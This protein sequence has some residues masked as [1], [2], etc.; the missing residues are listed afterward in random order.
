MWYHFG[1]RYFD[2]IFVGSVTGSTGYFQ[3]LAYNTASISTLTI[4]S[5]GTFSGGITGSTG[6]F[7]GLIYAKGGI[8]SSTG[9]FD[10]VM[11]SETGNS[12]FYSQ[13]GTFAGGITA[14]TGIFSSLIMVHFQEQLDIL[15]D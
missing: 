3:N 13:T 6:Y 11:A 7:S 12:C 5:T 2:S 4:T 8:T 1:Y 14:S 15:V 10:G 9:W